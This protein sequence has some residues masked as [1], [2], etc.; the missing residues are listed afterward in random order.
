MNHTFKKFKGFLDAIKNEALLLKLWQ[1]GRELFHSNM[2]AYLI[3]NESYRDHLLNYLTDETI[4]WSETYHIK[5]KRKYLNMDIV[6]ICIPKNSTDTP[7]NIDYWQ[8]WGENFT[9]EWHHIVIENKFKS[10]PSKQQLDKYDKKIKPHHSQDSLTEISKIWDKEN[11]FKLNKKPTIK[12]TKK[13][14]KRLLIPNNFSTRIN[15]NDWEIKTWKRISEI[16]KPQNTV[17]NSLEYNFIDSYCK[18]I[19]ESCNIHDL[20]YKVIHNSDTSFSKLDEYRNEAFE[21]KLHDFVDKWRYQWLS[22]LIEEKLLVSGFNVLTP[23]TCKNINLQGTWLEHN[24]IH[25]KIEPIF[26]RGTAGVDIAIYLESDTLGVQLQGNTLKIYYLT[27]TK[28]NE[29]DDTKNKKHV[30]KTRKINTSL[31]NETNR[32]TGKINKDTDTDTDLQYFQKI[33]VRYNNCYNYVDGYFY[34]KRVQVWNEKKFG[35]H[36]EPWGNLSTE[37]IAYQLIKIIDILKS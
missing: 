28:Q 26:S 34:Y 25:L 21:L 31:F 2:L 7:D 9:N 37:C 17:N 19:E 20:L 29:T 32:I 24:K 4:K 36:E 18:I 35:N 8:Y 22:K 13:L 30:T 12:P 23:T 11:N 14:T 16:A 6:I 3:E 10:L 33:L 1:S 15:Y 5:V 27:D